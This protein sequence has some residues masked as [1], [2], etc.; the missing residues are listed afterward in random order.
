MQQKRFKGRR[1]L[2]A[3]LC[4]AAAI[5]LCG[6]TPKPEPIAGG[7]TDKTDPNAPKTITSHEITAFSAS[8]YLR[9]EWTPGQS[10]RLYTFTVAEEDGVLMASEPTLGVSKPADDALLSALDETIRAYDLIAQNGVYRVTAGLAPDYQKCSVEALYASGETLRFTVNNDPEAAWAKAVYLIFADW[11]AQ[12]GDD[13]LLPPQTTGTV[14]SI[15]LQQ[16][17]NGAYLWYGGVNVQEQNAIDGERHLFRRE[18]MDANGSWGTD[19]VRFPADFYDRVT[20]IVMAYDLRAFDPFSVLYGMGRSDSDPGD[21]PA[22]ELHMEFDN[23][24]WMQIDT[25][26]EADLAALRPLLSDLIAYFDS[27]FA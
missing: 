14:T 12:N 27:L 26:D 17:E 16:N 22:L 19:Y 10:S 8:F 21:A 6:C 5:G 24:R 15:T 2:T 1:F 11:F 4:A 25:S 7:T 20:E 13:S 3:L 18:V 9:G 23:G